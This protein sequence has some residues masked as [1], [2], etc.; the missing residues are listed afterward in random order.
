MHPS[1]LTKQGG[2]RESELTETSY[3]DE[4]RPSGANNLL[5]ASM[6]ETI[7]TSRLRDLENELIERERKM[8]A[9]HLRSCGAIIMLVTA[10]LIFV[11]VRTF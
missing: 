1:G 3:N 6:D 10:A 4:G 11:A 7:Q 2:Q 5:G 9:K 8:R